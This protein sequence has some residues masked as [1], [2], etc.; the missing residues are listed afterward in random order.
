MSELNPQPLPPGSRISVHVPTSALYNLDAMQKITAQVL[1]KLGCGGCHSGR[2][3]DFK[4]LSRFVVNPA[5]LEVNEF[6]AKGF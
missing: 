2:I 5:T 4:E 6:P 1:S 3:L